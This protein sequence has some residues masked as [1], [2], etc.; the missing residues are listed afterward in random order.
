MK[1]YIPI[2]I[3][4]IGLFGLFKSLIKLDQSNK[5][6]ALNTLV[7]T[8]KIERAIPVKEKTNQNPTTNALNAAPIGPYLESG[9]VKLN[10]KR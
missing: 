4:A 10:S 6:V 1:K 3:V 2:F 5:K 9:K 7:T 8:E